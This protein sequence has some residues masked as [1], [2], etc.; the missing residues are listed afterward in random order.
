MHGTGI[1]W[2]QET[3]TGNSGYYST[4]HDY[5]VVL[6]GSTS[7]TQEHAG[8]G[9]VIAPYLVRVVSAF[10]QQSKRM[11]SLKLRVAEGQCCLRKRIRA[12]FRKTQ[13]ERQAFYDEATVFTSK[14]AVRGPM[15]VLGD[16][17]ACLDRRLSGEEHIIGEGPFSNA[18]AR[19]FPTA[20]RH[21]L[22]ELCVRTRVCIAKTFCLNPEGELVTCDNVG[23]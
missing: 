18:T 12:T 5:L 15:Y 6:S 14:S 4:G 19:I 13:D 7:A 8:V 10:C 3:P 16:W 2:L 17:N 11:A 22:K 9:F 23:H 21:L 20:N 1:I